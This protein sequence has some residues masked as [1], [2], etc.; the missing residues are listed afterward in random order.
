MGELQ[1]TKHGQSCKCIIHI[2]HQ[3]QVLF[4]ICCPRIWWSLWHGTSRVVLLSCHSK[5]WNGM[6]GIT[7]YFYSSTSM[8]QVG[9]SVPNWLKITSLYVKKVLPTQQILLRMLSNIRGGQYYNNLP[10]VLSSF[11]V[12]MILFPEWK[13]ISWEMICEWRRH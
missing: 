2:H 13:A 8:V 11:H 5:R 7:C 12:I 9:E 1:V 10:I 4:K 3:M 6:R